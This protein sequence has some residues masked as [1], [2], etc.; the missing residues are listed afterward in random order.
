M[1]L[2]KTLG[3]APAQFQCSM[4][5]CSGG[6]TARLAAALC[7]KK[8]PERR[9]WLPAIGLRAVTLIRSTGGL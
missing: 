8:Q 7:P 6:A 4:R 5:I 9:F 3:N 2:A 1:D